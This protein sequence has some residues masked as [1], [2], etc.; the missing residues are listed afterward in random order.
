MSRQRRQRRSVSS[1]AFLWPAVTLVG[2][3]VVLSGAVESAGFLGRLT[4][5]GILSLPLQEQLR[6]LRLLAVLGGGVLTIISVWRWRGWRAGVG[7]MV[8]SLGCSLLM[9]N[10]LYPNHLLY[11]P[12]RLVRAALGEE[13]LL[14]DYNPR[15][16]VTLPVHEV[17]QAKF[18]VV[19]IHAHFRRGTIRTPE[20]ILAIMD[21][22]NVEWTNDLDGELDKRLQEEI[23]RYATP[24]PDRLTIFATVWY[25]P[26]PIHWDYF[27][28]SVAQLDNA[29]RLGAKGIKMW[30]N[31]GLKTVDEHH[32]LIPV[33]DPRIDEV[34]T[35]AGELQLPILIHLGDPAAFFDPIDRFNERYEELKTSLDWSFYG[36]QYPSLQTVLSQ[37]ERVVSHHPET[38]FILA[39]VANRT[40]DLQAA[41]G[42]LNRHPN[43]YMDIAARISELG[44]QPGLARDFFIRYQDRLV[45]GT[46]GNPSPD[47]YRSSFRFLETA[48]EYFDYPYWP[49]DNYG[50]WKIYGIHLPD[51]VLRKVYH[52]NAAK[53]LGLPLLA[54]PEGK[55]RG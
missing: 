29:K 46:D 12:A 15:P 45:F 37:F 36:P 55:R 8:A 38:T 26:G 42:M 23:A 13:L 52:D 19:N 27:H 10:C 47:V 14:S 2:L 49:R 24:H 35:K 20:E 22:T 3:V 43:L 21:A 16:R 39:H 28:W 17:R 40:D 1:G 51:E 48:D 31:L 54:Q 30:K 18:P 7:T 9:V 6:V 41:A 5:R 34:W 4:S 32:K 50:R 44:R 11:Q 25:P 33:D 53:L